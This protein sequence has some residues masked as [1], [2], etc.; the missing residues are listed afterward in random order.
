MKKIRSFS[1]WLLAIL[2]PSAKMIKCGRNW[3]I[4]PV[5][6]GTMCG[7]SLCDYGS[8]SF[9]N[10]RTMSQV[11]NSIKKS[12]IF[13][14]KLLLSY[15][16]YV[17]KTKFSILTELCIGFILFALISIQGSLNYGGACTHFT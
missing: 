10:W 12:L 14:L 16:N 15:G 9:A 1:I 4:F 3:F 17:G 6:L 2:S 13:Y 8:H 7:L 11:Q 5:W